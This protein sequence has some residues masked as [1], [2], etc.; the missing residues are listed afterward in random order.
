M[1]DIVWRSSQTELFGLGAA[2][3]L[4]SFAERIT[5]KIATFPYR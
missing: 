4:V 3:I 5:K 1:V 2:A